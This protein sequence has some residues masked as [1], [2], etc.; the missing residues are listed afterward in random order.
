[1]TQI[2]SYLLTVSYHIHEWSVRNFSH[3]FFLVLEE[4]DGNKEAGSI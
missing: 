2:K 3:V 1:M 4:T